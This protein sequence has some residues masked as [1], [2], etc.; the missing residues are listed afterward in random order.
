MNVSRRALLG[1]ALGSLAA[2]AAGCARPADPA[3]GGAPGETLGLGILGTRTGADRRPIDESIR[4]EQGLRVAVGWVTSRTNR[5]GARTISMA[6]ADDRNDPGAAAA[7]AEEL[8]DRGCRILVGGF[9]DPVALRLAEVAGR[10]RVLFIAATATADELTGVNRYTF[11]SGPEIT[12][13]LLAARS[14][15]RPGGRLVVL[16][17]DRA[18]AARAASMLGAAATMVLPAATTNFAAVRRIRAAQVYVDWPRPEPRLWTAIPAGVQPITILGAR[19]TWHQYGTHAPALRF[20]TPY[21]DGAT[22]N[23]GYQ[24]LRVAVP[25]RRSDT[26]HAEGFAAGQ[27][28]VRAFQS[29]VRGTDDMIRSLADLELNGVKT[30]LTVRAGDHLLAQGL[31]GGRL[32]WVGASGALTAVTEREFTPDETTPA[33]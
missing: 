30:G 22:S 19:N 25:D 21:V 31:W 9:T 32:T 2:T 1:A 23:N 20:V 24:A 6:R 27:M 8:V 33:V 29:G 26:G 16:A 10:R 4:F 18:R 15:V 12:Q 13:L 11:R 3:T 28:I 14:Y 7:A 17:A 5:I